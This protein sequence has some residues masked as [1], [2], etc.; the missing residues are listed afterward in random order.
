VALGFAVLAY[1]TDKPEHAHWL[2]PEERRWLVARL[3]AE[4]ASVAARHGTQ[5]RRA[6]TEPRVWKLGL[7]YFALLLGIYGVSLWLPQ[8]VAGLA[9]MSNFMVGV[10]TAIPYLAASIAMI[11]VG[12]HSDRTGERRWHI[13]APA[14]AGA[15]GFAASA[16][17]GHPALAL[18]G[19]SLAALGI[20]SA[21]GP[22]WTLPPSFLAGSGAAG[23]I[24]LIN[25]VGNLGGFVGPYALGLLKQETGSFRAGLL[26][27]AAAL[28]A[29]AAL[30]LRLP[31]EG[32]AAPDP[33]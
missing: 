27:L 19:L 33:G 21:L 18:A 2:A 14:L 4:R 22:F 31:R 8:I 10:V 29:V 3:A 17:T 26:L 15:L 30:A 6:F 25:S 23:G 32:A 24:A 5:L 12:S 20:W 28:L 13:A 11:L 1:L 9:Q 16:G 7:L